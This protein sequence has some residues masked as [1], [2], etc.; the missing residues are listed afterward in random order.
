MNDE[1]AK[2]ISTIDNT[3]ESLLSF[4]QVMV[5]ELRVTI[6]KWKLLFTITSCLDRLLDR[7]T[8]VFI[9]ESFT[10]TCIYFNGHVVMQESQ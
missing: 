7:K 10:Q 4:L 5:V 8:L 2:K 3:L 1:I 9:Y 6:E